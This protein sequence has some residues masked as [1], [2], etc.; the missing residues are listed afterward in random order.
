MRYFRL[1]DFIWCA[2]NMVMQ[3]LYSF[4]RID[5]LF[6]NYSFG[7][8]C[9]NDRKMISD[10]IIISLFNQKEIKY[11]TSACQFVQINNLLATSVLC[12]S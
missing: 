4:N 1:V 8:L 9:I 12:V 11:W 7:K 2:D 10:T 6:T 3:R 5:A